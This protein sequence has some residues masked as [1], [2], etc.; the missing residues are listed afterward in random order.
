MNDDRFLD[1]SLGQP[2][3]EEAASAK[4]FVL[5]T[6]VILYDREVLGQFQEH[7]LAI[8]ITVLE[9]LDRFKKGGTVL[10]QNARVFLRHIDKLSAA[11]DLRQW[12]PLN[13]TDSGCLSVIAGERE[14]REVDHLF[15][16]KSNDHRILASALSLSRKEASRRV[17]LVSKDINL[18][19]KARSLGLVAEDYE[20]VRVEN[21]DRLYTGRSVL[22]LGSDAGIDELYSRG[23]LDIGE[24]CDDVPSP[25][26]YFVMR[27]PSRS[28]LAVYDVRSGG[29]RLLRKPNAYGIR[30]RNAEQTFALDAV[31]NDDVPLVTLTGAAGTG[32]TLIALAGA[33]E[34]RRS[35]RQIF[36]ARPIVP[37]SNRDLGYLPGD[38][39]SKI[40]PYMQP[41]WDNLSVIRGS[42]NGSRAAGHIDDMLETE[43]L[44][45]VPLAYLRGRSLSRVLFIV[46]EAQNL[47]PHEV[48]TVITRAGEGT[49]VVFTGDI[50]QI[51][52]P[53]LDERSNGLSYLVDKMRGH[54]LYAQVNL[55]KGVRSDLANAASDRL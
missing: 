45:V 35:Y 16:G 23:E 49:K 47:T 39:D 42:L 2:T 20:S 27:G 52:T 5:D 33:L 18:R 14:E 24:V 41:L 3:E 30:P 1:P 19:V 32:K 12:I 46:D 7:D 31:L 11:R 29:L 13:G 17:V 22:R 6:S 48:K 10:S 15:G 38:V 50:F 55:E 54:D 44:Q 9:E 36:L 8:P 25:H 21:V 26:H 51:D 28:A 37:L 40:G 53:Y 34:Q 43:K 4:V